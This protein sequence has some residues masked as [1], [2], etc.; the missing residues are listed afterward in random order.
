[1]DLKEEILRLKKEKNAVSGGRTGCSPYLS[2]AMFLAMYMLP[3]FFL[4]A[5]FVAIV[6]V[7]IGKQTIMSL[8]IVDKC[9]CALFVLVFVLFLTVLIPLRS[10]KMKNSIL[11]LLMP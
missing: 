11:R 3:T 2:V 5:I 8:F 4:S 1:M 9:A 10:P 6:M 7:I